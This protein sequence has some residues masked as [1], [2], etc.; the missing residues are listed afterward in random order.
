MTLAPV[1]TNAGDGAARLSDSPR[2]YRD[3]GQPF[4]VERARK[5]L[6]AVIPSEGDVPATRVYAAAQAAGIPRWAVRKARRS[7]RA[8]VSDYPGFPGWAVR[9]CAPLLVRVQRRG[10]GTSGGWYW[11]W[12]KKAE[13]RTWVSE[14]EEPEPKVLR[15]CQ[16][17]DCGLPPGALGRTTARL[18]SW[19]VVGKRGGNP[20]GNDVPTI[21]G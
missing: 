12:T 3:T 8:P 15:V 10:Y 9:R 18:T 13:P 4:P 19:R 16:W 1:R 5:L 11:S 17:G 2:V 20:S 6:R 14:S 7:L 21:A